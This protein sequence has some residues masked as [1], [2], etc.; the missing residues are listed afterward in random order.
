MAMLLLAVLLALACPGLGK[1]GATAAE[2]TGSPYPKS[3][4]ISGIQFFAYTHKRRANGSDNWPI[5]WSADDHQ[6]T[7]WGDG[8]GFEGTDVQERVSLGFGRVE[9]LSA[10]YRARNVW[11]GMHA[12][13][14]ATF[15]GKSYGMLAIGTELYAWRCGDG[16]G[17]ASMFDFQRLYH[18]ANGGRSW[19]AAGWEFPGTLTFYCPTFLQFGKGYEG[20]RDGYVYMYAA[21]RNNDE[22]GI[23]KPGMI[24][25]MRAPAGR[26]MD[27]GAYEFFTGRTQSGDATWSPDVQARQPVIEDPNGLRL[28]SAAYNAGLDRYLVGYGH[29]ERRLGNMALLDGPTPWGP[30]TTVTY[31]YGWG[32]GLFSGTCCLLWHFAPKWWSDGGRGFTMVFSGGDQADSWNT[33]EGR[34]TVEETAASPGSDRP[35]QPPSTPPAEDE[36]EGAEAPPVEATPPQQPT[37]S[38]QEQEDESEPEQ[39]D[40]PGE[41]TVR[42]GDAPAQSAEPSGLRHSLAPAARLDRTLAEELAPWGSLFP[43]GVFG[44]RV[45][46]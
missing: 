10:T 37:A 16:V 39:A 14:P 29:T 31:E 6:Y 25:L 36:D 32:K 42:Q 26:L 17:I 41:A 5:T 15:K 18:S 19:Q 30:W 12:E 28:V 44:T 11:G 23:H 8:G 9:G 4:V 13:A 7:A 2:G 20:A 40:A 24:M 45:E 21:E 35:G 43:P 3:P 33:I 46:R 27:Q 22:W 1:A 34:F 38:A